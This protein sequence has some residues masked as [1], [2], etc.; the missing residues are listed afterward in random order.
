VLLKLTRF[1]LRRCQSPVYPRQKFEPVTQ[2]NGP[3]SGEKQCEL[4]VSHQ[5]LVPN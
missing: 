4:S 2:V 3:D 1:L 5:L